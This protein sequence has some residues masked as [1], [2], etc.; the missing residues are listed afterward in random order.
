VAVD[1]YSV[2]IADYENSYYGRLSLTALGGRRAAA[3]TVVPAALATGGVAARGDSL[4]SDGVIRELV[5]LQLYEDALRE[6]QYAQRQWGDTPQLQATT[7]YIRHNQGL[8]LKAEDRFSAV[9]GA[10]TTMRRAYPQFMAA[11]G[12]EL[13]A[14]VLRIIFP[15]D[16]WPLITKYSKLND[17]DPFLVAALMAQES[18]FTAEIRSSANAYG[19]M[20]LIPATGSR[21]AK[22]L[23]I[24]NFSTRM[25]KDPETNIKLGTEYFKD[26]IARFGGAHYALAGYNAGESRVQQWLNDRGQL[27]ADEFTDDIPFPETQNYVKRILGTAEDYRHLYGGGL[28]DPN[29]SLSAQGALASAGTPVATVASNHSTP[30]TTGSTAKKTTTKKTT[31]K[32]STTKR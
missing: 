21:Y 14:E 32:K 20:Q 30:P 1:R 2:V 22:K 4:P 3:L 7:A 26:L 13:P 19:L 27:P 28:L 6:V 25:L 10:I 24:R 29:D 11:G 8:T 9:R 17:L 18:T 5:S 15:I 31:S 12:Q 23:G 16:Y